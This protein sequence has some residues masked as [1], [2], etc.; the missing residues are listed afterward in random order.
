VLRHS[1]YSGL[2]TVIRKAQDLTTGNILLDL[3]SVRMPYIFALFYSKTDPREFLR[4]RV[5][6]RSNPAFENVLEFGRF[7]F[8]RRFTDTSEV[9]IVEAGQDTG[10]DLFATV[11]TE[12]DYAVRV[13]RK[14]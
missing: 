3:P 5:L 7:R 14:P 10:R 12:G 11:M 6:E 13:R 1:F 8:D 2:G 4:T 9:I